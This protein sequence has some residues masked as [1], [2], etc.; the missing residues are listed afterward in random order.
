MNGPEHPN[1]QQIIQS[2]TIAIVFTVGLGLTIAVRP[3]STTD[4]ALAAGGILLGTL[5]TL[6]FLYRRSDIPSL[7]VV[8]FG[9]GMVILA[10]LAAVLSTFGYESMV[11]LGIGFLWGPS[12][13]YVLSTLLER[14]TRPEGSL[15]NS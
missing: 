5:S 13:G 7:K 9:L 8:L 14:R 4:I 6:V 12:I 1:L 15:S 10:L 11:V 2:T 3:V